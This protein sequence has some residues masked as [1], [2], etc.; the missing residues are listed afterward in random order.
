M[1]CAVSVVVALLGLAV[2]P[3]AGQVPAT[4][5]APR[6]AYKDGKPDLTGL[7]QA[8][9]TAN[10]DIQDH[11]A[12][13]GPIVELGAAFSIPAGLGVVEGNGSLPAI[14]GGE[15]EENAANWLKLDPEIK[16]YLAGCAARHLH[17]LSISNRADADTHPDR[18]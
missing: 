2:I 6:T 10:W 4:Y 1:A 5:K 8:N 16:C 12:R 9:N 7:W 17:A 14:G 3:T 11:T 13:Q 18:V 15:K